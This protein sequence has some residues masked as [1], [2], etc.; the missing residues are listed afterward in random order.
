MRY[1]LGTVCVCAC[2][3]EVQT[4][5]TLLPR[6]MLGAHSA[7]MSALVLAGLPTTSTLTVLDATVLRYSPWCVCAC[8]HVSRVL[9]YSPCHKRTLQGEP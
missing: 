8:L 5:F 9:R 1:V 2:V 7:A 3:R 4:S 6:G